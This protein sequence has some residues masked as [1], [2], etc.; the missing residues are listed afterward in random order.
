[1]RKPRTPKEFDVNDFLHPARAYR[2]PMEV[3]ADEDL[4]VH[5]KRAILA[6]WA[7]DACSVEA[8]PDVRRPPAAPLVRFED[9]MDAL[10]QLDGEA[11]TKPAYG[12]FINRAR[13]WKEL[14]RRDRGGGSLRT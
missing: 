14:Y 12:K 10:K 3:V 5:E 1:M 6:S 13:R 9:I 7:S 11:A 2:I 4:T 8:E